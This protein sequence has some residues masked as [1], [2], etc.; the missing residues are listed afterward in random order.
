MPVFTSFVAKASFDVISKQDVL[1]GRISSALLSSYQIV[2]QCQM[3]ISK[4]LLIPP[5]ALKGVSIILRFWQFAGVAHGAQKKEKKEIMFMNCLVNCYTWCFARSACR[6]S[7]LPEYGEDIRLRHG[8]AATGQQVKWYFTMCMARGDG[9][10]V[11]AVY[12]GFETRINSRCRSIDDERAALPVQILRGEQRLVVTDRFQMS[13]FTPQFSADQRKG[14][15]LWL[16]VRSTQ[17]TEFVD[18]KLRSRLN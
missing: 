17:R 12:R 13:G 9:W 4:N 14:S 3:R 16:A 11:A 18:P 7:I 2:V 10:N 1:N 5:N 6:P 8:I 15:I